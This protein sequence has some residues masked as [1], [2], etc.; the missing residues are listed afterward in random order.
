[1]DKSLKK[2]IEE[3]FDELI[4]NIIN[5]F[6]DQNIIEINHKNNI[7]FSKSPTDHSHITKKSCTSI[8]Q[9][10]LIHMGIIKADYKLS[11][12]DIIGIIIIIENKLS[13]ESIILYMG[14]F[15]NNITSCDNDEQLLEQLNNMIISRFYT[16]DIEFFKTIIFNQYYLNKKKY[17]MEQKTNNTDLHFIN[18]ISYIDT[19]LYYLIYKPLTN[20]TE[21]MIRTDRGILD[22]GIDKYDIYNIKSISMDNLLHLNNRLDRKHD[23]LSQEE[24]REIKDH[25]YFIDK[26]KPFLCS[27]QQKE[28]LIKSKKKGGGKKKSKRSHECPSQFYEIPNYSNLILDYYKMA[29]TRDKWGFGDGWEIQSISPPEK[30]PDSEKKSQSWFDYFKESIFRDEERDKGYFKNENMCQ[31]RTTYGDI[32]RGYEEFPEPAETRRQAIEYSVPVY[33]LYKKDKK[34]DILI[35]KLNNISINKKLNELWY[36]GD[37][38]H[39]VNIPINPEYNNIYFRKTFSFNE[40]YIN[41]NEK[42]LEDTTPTSDEFIH[43][44][45]PILWF[46]KIWED[47]FNEHVNKDDKCKN[48]EKFIFQKDIMVNLLLQ[49]KRLILLNSKFNEETLCFFII[50]GFLMY[51][52]SNITKDNS[53]NNQ[54][55]HVFDKEFELNNEINTFINNDASKY[56]G[57]LYE[58]IPNILTSKKL[59]KHLDE[60]MMRGRVL[61]QKKIFSKILLFN[62]FLSSMSTITLIWSGIEN[63]YFR[64]DNIE[65]LNKQRDELKN[66]LNELRN[67]LYFGY[68]D[69][70]KDLDFLRGLARQRQV[71]NFD[72]KYQLILSLESQIKTLDKAIDKISPTNHEKLGWDFA[73]ELKNVLIKHGFSGTDDDIIR[74]NEQ[75][76]PK[77]AETLPHQFIQ[78]LQD[79]H[80]SELID[81]YNVLRNEL[82]FGYDDY[83]KDLDFLR[84]LERQVVNFE[85]KRKIL[86]SLENQIK[87]LDKANEIKGWVFAQELKSLLKKHELSYNDSDI[88]LINEQWWPKIA[89]TNPDQFFQLLADEHSGIHS[90]LKSSNSSETHDIQS[91][92]SFTHHYT[93][94]AQARSMPQRNSK[95]SLDLFSLN[96]ASFAIPQ[97]PNWINLILVS[98]HGVEHREKT[99]DGFHTNTTHFNYV[100]Q[101][102]SGV[103]YTYQNNQLGSI[104]MVNQLNSQE[105]AL[106]LLQ[107]NGTQVKKDSSFGT[108]L[109]FIDY[110]ADDDDNALHGIY[111]FSYNNITKETRQTKLISNKDLKDFLKKSGRRS[112]STI[113]LTHYV[114]QLIEKKNI[115]NVRVL[116]SSCQGFVNKTIFSNIPEFKSYFQNE[117]FSITNMFTFIRE[118]KLDKA[119]EGVF[120][121]FKDSQ[122]FGTV[123]GVPYGVTDETVLQ[124]TLRNKNYTSTFQ[125]MISRSDVKNLTEAFKAPHVEGNFFRQS[126]EDQYLYLLNYVS[127]Y[128]SE[129]NLKYIPLWEKENETSSYKDILKLWNDPTLRSQYNWDKLKIPNKNLP[130]FGPKG[131]GIEDKITLEKLD[132]YFN[133][134]LPINIDNIEN[135]KDFLSK[136]I[137]KIKKIENQFNMLFTM[138]QD[139][140]SSK[141]KKL[142]LIYVFT[143]FFQHVFPTIEDKYDK[144]FKQIEIIKKKIEKINAKIYHTIDEKTYFIHF[145]SMD[146]ELINLFEK[147]NNGETIDLSDYEKIITNVWAKYIF[148]NDVSLTE[149]NEYILNEMNRIDNLQGEALLLISKLQTINE[150]EEFDIEF[151]EDNSNIFFKDSLR[152]KLPQYKKNI[153][154]HANA[155]INSIRDNYDSYTLNIELYMKYFEIINEQLKDFKSNISMINEILTFIRTYIYSNFDK[156]SKS[157][158][159]VARDKIN[160]IL[161]KN[162]NYEQNLVYSQHFEDVLRT[163]ETHEIN[164]KN[165]L[166][167]IRVNDKS[168]I[169]NFMIDFESEYDNLQ[170]YYIKK[171]LYYE[172]DKI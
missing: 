66:K 148:L 35:N 154:E 47:N 171:I 159:K 82:Y 12:D 110:S 95:P 143:Y 34:D 91:A 144:Y 120:V 18:M 134:K 62:S 160:Q 167:Y 53:S 37:D 129:K 101:N 132:T 145:N 41:D 79:I 48:F 105:L 69:Y 106:Y 109:P 116:A 140:F 150:D 75:W 92:D 13:K 126:I 22:D 10:I 155:Y 135:S 149:N 87:A 30:L 15:F 42:I 17:N 38:L 56:L 119:L 11:R 29:D 33:K 102:T 27:D 104:S 3:R 39:V 103:Q 107:T 67:E 16:N 117:Y 63:I 77:F 88:I 73:G 121:P 96:N 51:V 81:K 113:D 19:L 61:E 169:K 133:T 2:N 142:Y 20:D 74:I 45:I 44:G 137:S 24:L 89:I 23:E 139:S 90:A 85:D 130:K 58:K 76:F 147:F 54:S 136:I 65:I 166:Y 94:P 72:D 36:Y 4:V 6:C 31:R 162:F 127:G 164:D 60:K 52:T 1:M 43:S 86:S 25:R 156:L 153:K 118:N 141:D 84:G 59:D 168:K 123:I 28:K 78:F 170:D 14:Y 161:I 32:V 146:V 83:G 55:Y 40:L 68:D 97:G 122:P 80:R 7:A 124:Y 100:L 9:Q 157:L 151:D 5:Y 125:L 8:I 138:E 108:L 165:L 70:G 163:L 112:F 128:S 46:Y 172:L 21:V 93:L 49:F 57:F 152:L 131:G 64:E 26:N 50:L 115:S 111:L 71:D 158:T 98:V 114:N 99:H